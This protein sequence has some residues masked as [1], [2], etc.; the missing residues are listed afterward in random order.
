[1]NMMILHR[2]SA[3]PVAYHLRPLIS[4]APLGS[5]VVPDVYSNRATSSGFRGTVGGGGGSC[6]SARESEGS[7]GASDSSGNTRASLR[8]WNSRPSVQSISLGFTKIAAAGAATS[9]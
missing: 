4:I 5:P 6:A 9:Q 3:A 8:D 7:A 2:G 1:M